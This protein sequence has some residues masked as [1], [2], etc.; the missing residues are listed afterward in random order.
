M[1]VPAMTGVTDGPGHVDSIEANTEHPAL[2]VRL[3][4]TVL[5]AMPELIGPNRYF[6]LPDLVFP[7]TEAKFEVVEGIEEDIR[8]KVYKLSVPEL[9]L[10]VDDA[11][12]QAS[13]PFL[14]KFALTEL[15]ALTKK[16]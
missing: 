2:Q 8:R 9:Q 6:V 16:S 10:I 11:E 1:Q 12:V 5:F 13:Q 3:P 14:H 15:D 7:L 4:A